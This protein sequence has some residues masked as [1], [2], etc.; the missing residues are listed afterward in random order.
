MVREGFQEAARFLVDTVARVPADRWDAPALGVW[1]VRELTAHASGAFDSIQAHDQPHRIAERVEIEGAAGFYL[2]VIGP[3][4][5][6]SN[7]AARAKET[8]A[9]F[10]GDPAG[11]LAAMADG[12]LAVLD[13]IPDDKPTRSLAGGMRFV[14]WLATRV[15]E[16]TVHGVDIADA[17][18]IE[19]APPPQAMRVTLGVLSDIAIAK[20]SAT[21][22]ALAVTGR[23]PLR[24]GFSLF[25]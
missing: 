19:V 11:T 3:Q 24:D 10:V 18:G 13:G 12:A 7:I 14:D 21:E 5:Q 6:D 23:R 16:L 22:L 2:A 15:V 4:K 8:V 1:S 25:D 9:Q 17:A 20:G